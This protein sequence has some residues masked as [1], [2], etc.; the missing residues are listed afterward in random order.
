M[1]QP[2]LLQM[3]SKLFL[4]KQSKPPTSDTSRAKAMVPE[5]LGGLK[6]RICKDIMKIIKVKEKYFFSCLYSKSFQSSTQIIQKCATLLFLLGTNISFTLYSSKI[7]DLQHGDCKNTHS[8]FQVNTIEG[9][10]NLYSTQ[11][12]SG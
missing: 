4:L 5:Q 11:S 12:C 7:Y 9:M 6:T 8:S 3:N 2:V 10:Q 1:A